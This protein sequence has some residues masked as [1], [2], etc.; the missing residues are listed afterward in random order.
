MTTHAY[1]SIGLCCIV[2]SP[3]VVVA[4]MPAFVGLTEWK[5]AV[6]HDDRLLFSPWA[7]RELAGTVA[8][9]SS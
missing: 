7:G 6:R 2:V 5:Y 3:F 1:W 4:V 8:A 9:P